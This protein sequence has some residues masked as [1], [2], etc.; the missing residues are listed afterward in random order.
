MFGLDEQLASI[1]DGSAFALV[2]VVAIL[3]GLRHATDPD[4]LTAVSTLV[5]GAERDA[6]G[7]AGLG[8]AW[9]AGHAT[10]L[11]TFGV[12]I[13]L[14]RAYL[15]HPVQMG[16]EAAVGVVIVV[17]AL[18]LLARWRSGELRHAHAG[19]AR[20]R[21]QAYAI[22]LVHGMGGSAG[23][24]VLLLA[25]IPGHAEALAALALFAACTALSMAAASTTLGVVLTRDA[26]A[27]RHLALAPAL[28]VLSLAFGLWYA[29]G[30]VDAVPYVF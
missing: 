4:H 12:P 30:A 8:L 27:Q 20:S 1:G 29:L 2:L 9:G 7:A 13:V 18:R 16:A 24:G 17:L 25:A 5:A 14:F 22:G 11:L 21:R 19:G 15:P 23:V 26:V 28:G 6:R 10:S 3:L